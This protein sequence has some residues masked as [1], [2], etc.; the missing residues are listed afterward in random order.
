MHDLFVV[1]DCVIT[2]LSRNC[3]LLLV[4][5]RGN[6][7]CSTGD[8]SPLL[9]SFGN[10]VGLAI[11]SSDNIFIADYACHTVRV[12]NNVSGRCEIIAGKA[13]SAG[14]MDG[15]GSNVLFNQPFGVALDGRGNLFVSEVAGSVIRKIVLNYTKFASSAVTTY[16]G[17]GTSQFVNG[18]G[19]G[20]SF[21]Q[22][23]GIAA[24]TDGQ[25]YVVCAIVLYFDHGGAGPPRVPCPSR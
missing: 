18:V 10:T 23:Y 9:T 13:V 25:L 16:A 17:S 2:S 7:A 1:V 19:T 12:I 3:L 14:R 21:Q 4:Y 20:A 22:P 6:R 8:V 15:L 24:D 5:V 11:D